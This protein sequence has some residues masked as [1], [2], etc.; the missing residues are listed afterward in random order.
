[1]IP[2][3][4]NKKKEEM[5]SSGIIEKMGW[6]GSV[7]Q[8]LRMKEE[9]FDRVVAAT[10]QVDSWWSWWSMSAMRE[11]SLGWTHCSTLL[12]IQ[13]LKY[14]VPRALSAKFI[15]YWSFSP[16]LSVVCLPVWST[17]IPASHRSTDGASSLHMKRR[18]TSSSRLLVLSWLALCQQH[19]HGGGPGVMFSAA[20]CC[21]IAPAALSS[22]RAFPG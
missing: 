19:L 1:M 15:L 5:L 13:A 11:Q 16:S 2:Q 17:R 8:W 20:A 12:Q 14:F 7:F 3:N 9:R 10:S 18:K 4:N 6:Q 22:P 21:I